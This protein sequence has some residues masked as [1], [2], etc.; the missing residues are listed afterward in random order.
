MKKIYKWRWSIVILL[1]IITVIGAIITFYFPIAILIAIGI[2]ELVAQ[3]YRIIIVPRLKEIES[4]EEQKESKQKRYD[5][6]KKI[7]NLLENYENV[8]DNDIN[9]KKY[10]SELLILFEKLT[11]IGF[12]VTEPNTFEDENYR[13]LITPSRK[14]RF[15]IKDQNNNKMYYS[16]KYEQEQN[17]NV[18]YP[19]INYLKDVLSK[20]I[21][22][23]KK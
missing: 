15:Y 2:N 10:I 19:F 9:E 7:I 12:G 23:N 21:N 5:P 1:T 18:L 6:I 17:S 3:I 16:K 8:K 14:K 13:I 4:K 22:S 20:W 11:L